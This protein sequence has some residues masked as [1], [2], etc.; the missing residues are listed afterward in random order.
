[1]TMRVPAG[2]G[3]LE[4]AGERF[5]VRGVTSGSFVPRADGL[6]IPDRERLFADVVRSQPTSRTS[7]ALWSLA[8]PS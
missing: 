7:T 4:P 6:L 8:S 5:V 3:H 1:M 2:G